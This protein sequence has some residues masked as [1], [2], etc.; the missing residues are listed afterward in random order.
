MQQK[1][2][3]KKAP[4]KKATKKTSA[5]MGRPTLYREGMAEEWLRLIEHEEHSITSACHQLGFTTETL[6]EWKHKYKDFSYAYKKAKAIDKDILQRKALSNEYNPTM[7]MFL[8]KANHGMIEADKREALDI[9]R[10]ELEK[11]DK[12]PSGGEIHVHITEKTS[13]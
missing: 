5:K 13:R 3:D 11:E 4:P 1:K 7:A 8:L 9:R 10:K 6:G 12:T 2:T